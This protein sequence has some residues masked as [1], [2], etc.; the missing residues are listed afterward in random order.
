MGPDSGYAFRTIRPVPYPG[1]TPHIH[2][3]VM[4]PGRAHMMTLFYVAGQPL[5]FAALAD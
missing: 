3:A 1:R 4:T 2:V 5:P